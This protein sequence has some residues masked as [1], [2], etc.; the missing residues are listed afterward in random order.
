LNSRRWTV[1]DRSVTVPRKPK[2][3]NSRVIGMRPKPSQSKIPLSDNQLTALRTE[4]DGR[5]WYCA[6]L[7]NEQLSGY[8]L[9]RPDLTY[10]NGH[11]PKVAVLFCP[12][13]S[14]QDNGKQ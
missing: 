12:A 13:F 10:R 4:G 7:K 5:K 14:F 3:V 11:P 9:R 8:F 6:R 1:L 2:L